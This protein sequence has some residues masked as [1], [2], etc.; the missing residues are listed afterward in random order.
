MLVPTYRAYLESYP[1]VTYHV[2]GI[3]LNYPAPSPKVT[4]CRD[5]EDGECWVIAAYPSSPDEWIEVVW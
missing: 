1:G 4:I 3:A 5:S 2:L